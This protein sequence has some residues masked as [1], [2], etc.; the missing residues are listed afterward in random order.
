[1]VDYTYI[2]Y[3]AAE[4]VISHEQEVRFNWAAYGGW[5]RWFQGTLA[6][7]LFNQC[8]LIVDT[9][10]PPTVRPE[11]LVNQ[12]GQR[13]DIVCY[14][15]NNVSYI[16]LKCIPF[17]AIAGGVN[18]LSYCN[19]VYNDWK[20]LYYRAA[21]QLISLVLIPIDVDGMG[22]LICD[23]LAQTARNNN[24]SY[25]CR[26]CVRNNDPYMYVCAFNITQH[27][28]EILTIQTI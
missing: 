10:V 1:M 7:Y 9:E 13:V 4:C 15:N 21:N 5:E 26:C 12:N 25:V 3:W 19:G 27:N 24:L 14:E 22:T 6:P 2:A 28:N 16:E 17:T 23:A 18:P 20:K 11:A 8:N